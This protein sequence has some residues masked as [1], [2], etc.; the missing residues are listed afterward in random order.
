MHPAIVSALAAEQRRDQIARAAAALLSREARRARRG[1]GQ[2]GP[3]GSDC[4]PGWGPRLP[5][6][7][8][9]HA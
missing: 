3:A 8:P 1:C 5:R 6:M 9:H 7:L 2:A 4:Q